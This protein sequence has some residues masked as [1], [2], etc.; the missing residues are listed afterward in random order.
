MGAGGE[1]QVGHRARIV[2][3]QLGLAPVP[4]PQQRSARQA[5]D[6]PGM[7]Q[8]GE[9]HAGNVAAAGVKPLEIPYRL[10]RVLK[11]LAEETAAVAAR[12]NAV[13]APLPFRQGADVQQIHH[14][15]VAGLR[16]GHAHRAGQE[17]HGAQVQVADV[18][19]AIVV[20]HIASGPVVALQHE[21]VAGPHPARHR[22]V[23]MPAVVNLRIV[24]RGL[25][26]IDLDQGG[27]H[28]ACSC[29]VGATRAPIANARN[30]RPPVT[31][32]PRADGADATAIRGL[33]R[34]VF[35]VV[36]AAQ[37]TGWRQA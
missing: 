31:V 4:F 24:V 32:R 25:I 19:G 1:R 7:D 12:K 18:V 9:T 22:N 11:V 29:T 16:A 8:A 20:A 34:L 36:R 2:A 33:R 10:L 26:E 23:R 13:E 17:M 14:Q 5:A 37:Q 6:Q 28:D 3:Q 35:F 15:Q 21:I 27:R 30:R